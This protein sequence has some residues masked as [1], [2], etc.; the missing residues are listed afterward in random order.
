MYEIQLLALLRPCDVGG[1]E[2]VHESF[3]I[4]PP[5]LRQGVADLPFVV[6][7]G[8]RE[9]GADGGKAL[10]EAEFEAGDFVVVGLEVVAW[11]GGEKGEGGSVNIA[12]FGRTGVEGN[13]WGGT[14]TV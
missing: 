4:G 5:P 9:L 8:A 10:V 11:S 2:G 1:Q 14:G 12:D 7:V 13:E 6:D 3:E